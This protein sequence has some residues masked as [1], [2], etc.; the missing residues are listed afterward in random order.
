MA[1]D[2]LKDER[3]IGEWVIGRE[4]IGTY[5]DIESNNI[6]WEQFEDLAN[7]VTIDDER[8]IISFKLQNGPIKEVGENGCQVDLLI[9]A[10]AAI[11][12]KFNG[13]I[14]CEEN[15]KCLAHLNMALGWLETRRQDRE[16][17]GVEG[18]MK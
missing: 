14:E 12:E 6:N 7:W 15:T 16:Y 17:R 13:I 10:A 2:V 1:L 8:N 9:Q 18:T 5:T 11:I 3:K 4:P